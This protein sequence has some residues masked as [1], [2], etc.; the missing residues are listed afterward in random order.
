MAFDRAKL[1]MTLQVL[2]LR[3]PRQLLSKFVKEAKGVLFTR[4]GHKTIVDDVDQKETK[5]MLLDESVSK[6]EQL[7]P[8][9]R[10]L[11][12][13]NHVT[14]ITHPVTLGIQHFSCEQILRR[15]LPENITVPT[16]FE[17][18]GHIAHLNLKDEHMPFKSL[19]GEVFLAKHQ[20]QIRTVVTKVGQI[21]NQF[22]VFDMDLIAGEDDFETCVK[23]H[24]STFFFNF[25]E[26]YWNSRLQTEHTRL[27]DEWQ[28]TDVICD[29]FCGVGPFAIPAGARGC[30]VYANDLNPRSV[31]YLKKNI[32]YNK[33]ADKVHPFNMDAREFVRHLRAEQK[34]GSVPP[35]QHVVMNLPAIAIEFLDVFDGLY[36]GAPSNFLPRIHCYCFASEDD[37]AAEVIKRVEEVLKCRVQA[38]VREVRHV[39]PK[40]YMMCVSFLL[41]GEV[42]ARPPSLTSVLS[43]APTS[44]TSLEESATSSAKSSRSDVEPEEQ[45]S[46]RAKQ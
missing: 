21:A 12:T 8:A 10:E 24:A 22:R 3:V 1:S 11:A 17:T 13:T 23:E 42:G 33:V 34:I 19:I 18:I 16:S 9:L 36:I 15:L 14:S 44:L 39:A 43:S 35:F 6:V 27:V 45:P 4:Q 46:K 2:A 30:T 41:P 37:K 20:P 32:Q 26:V 31:H 5:L 38:D 25:R 40:K 7:P 29:M 28:P